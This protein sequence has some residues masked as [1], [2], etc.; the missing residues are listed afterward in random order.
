[1]P[2]EKH[3]LTEDEFKNHKCPDGYVKDYQK[4]KC[5]KKRSY[6]KVGPRGGIV[7]SPKAPGS[8]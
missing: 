8:R 3:A 7:K 5:V 1:M 2:C 6:A 4:H